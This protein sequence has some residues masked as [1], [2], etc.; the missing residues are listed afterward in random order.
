MGLF[1]TA[2]HSEA[3]SDRQSAS[4]KKHSHSAV[5]PMGWVKVISE[6]SPV[7]NIAELQAIT[8]SIVSSRSAYYAFCAQTPDYANKMFTE[9]RP[10]LM[11]WHR[12]LGWFFAVSRYSPILEA[13]HPTKEIRIFKPFGRVVR[14]ARRE[15]SGEG[16][17]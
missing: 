12:I 4:A 6:S 14:G 16:A 2:K 9:V 17:I 7:S 8:K 11:A 13:A 3:P 15:W 10:S 1:A 5:K